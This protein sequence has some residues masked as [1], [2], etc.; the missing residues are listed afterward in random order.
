MSTE[1]QELVHRERSKG[2]LIVVMGLL[3]L[4]VVYILSPPFVYL[5]LGKPLNADPVCEVIYTPLIYLDREFPFVREFY[6]WY[7]S[8]FPGMP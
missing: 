1:E 2:G 7:G 5:M 4:L 8:L 6:E 3:L